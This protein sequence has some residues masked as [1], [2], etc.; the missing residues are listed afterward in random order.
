MEEVKDHYWLANDGL[1]FESK[2]ECDKYEKSIKR[3][4]ELKDGILKLK[5]ELAQLVYDRDYKTMR[6]Y[7]D[8]WQSSIWNDHDGCAYMCPHCKKHVGGTYGTIID[9]IK[10]DD[11]VYCCTNCGTYF[12]TDKY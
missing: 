4:K 5:T 11:D 1:R 12:T 6:K 7:A 10:V 9:G 2:E 8:N 3:E